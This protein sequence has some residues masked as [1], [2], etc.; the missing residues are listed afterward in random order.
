MERLL[1]IQHVTVW[2]I[3]MIFLVNGEFI[4]FKL[5]FYLISYTF[6]ILCILVICVLEIHFINT[7]ITFVYITQEKLTLYWKLMTNEPSYTTIYCPSVDAYN[8]FPHL[9]KSLYGF[10][11]RVCRRPPPYTILPLWWQIQK[12]YYSFISTISRPSVCQW[13]PINST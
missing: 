12:S 13:V 6:F 3:I 8:Y 10:L 5:T 1:E 7:E 11:V 9:H 2:L 4:I